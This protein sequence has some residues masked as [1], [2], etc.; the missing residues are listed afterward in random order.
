MKLD[1]RIIEGKRPL[2]AFDTEEAKQFIDK[3]GYFANSI[4]EFCN[5]KD[6]VDGKLFDVD[7]ST[8][9]PFDCTD[10]LS[11]N[12][13]YSF[14]LPKEWIKVNELKCRISSVEQCMADLDIKG[15]EKSDSDNSESTKGWCLIDPSDYA[16]I[17]RFC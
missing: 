8:N 11:D 7:D 4:D 13:Y 9:T 5:L 2:T 3:E 16:K 10:E 15:T 6:V 1:P 17:R 12:Y 14:F